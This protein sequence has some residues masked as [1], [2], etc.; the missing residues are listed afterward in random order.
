[1]SLNEPIPHYGFYNLV[2]DTIWY[3]MCLFLPVT[4]IFLGGY[5]IN[6]EYTED[7]FEEY[8]HCTSDISD[9]YLWQAH[10]VG[11]YDY[12]VLWV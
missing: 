4:M 9:T 8:V 5:M 1:M 2:N 11:N 3:N 10:S 12:A 7:T 6:R